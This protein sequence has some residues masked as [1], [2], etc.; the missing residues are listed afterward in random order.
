MDIQDAISSF[1]FAWDHTQKGILVDIE[2]PLENFDAVM[3]ELKSMGYEIIE[4]E[5]NSRLCGIVYQDDGT[6][7]GGADPRGDCKALGY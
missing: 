5:I 2:C 3:E 1:N 4:T 6:L 7:R